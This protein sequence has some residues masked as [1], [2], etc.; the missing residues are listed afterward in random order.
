MKYSINWQDFMRDPVNKALKE[1]KGI[2]ACK[3]KFIQEQNKMAWYDPMILNEAAQ[4]A[5]VV[6]NANASAGGSSDF[7]TGNTAHVDRFTWGTTLDG[8]TAS[9]NFGITVNNALNS[10]TSYANGHTDTRKKIL[11]LFLTG[12][13]VNDLAGISTTGVDCVVTASWTDTD[14]TGNSATGSVANVLADAVAAQTA[15]AVVG[16]FTNTIA[17]SDYI[18]V[19]TGSNGTYMDITYS[20]AGGV[21]PAVTDTDSAT[22][23]LAIQTLGTDTYYSEKGAQLFNGTEGPY[24]F[25]PRKY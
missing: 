8:F 17:A 13:T 23:S 15:T 6:N 14:I 25:M 11:L 21:T 16:T 18:T 1:S 3:Q 10:N 7:I 22:G 2:H 19:T 24:S 9:G 5:G 4:D 20:T 12:S